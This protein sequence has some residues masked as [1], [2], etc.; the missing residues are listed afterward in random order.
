[1]VGVSGFIEI[2]EMARPAVRR[3][4][5]EVALRVALL[6]GERP[7][8]AG[9]RKLGRGVVIESSTLPLGGR[10]ALGAVLGELRQVVV[11]CPA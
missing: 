1:V 9:Q 4:V 7:M 2:L 5:L 8:S 6:A 10:M 3:C 11:R